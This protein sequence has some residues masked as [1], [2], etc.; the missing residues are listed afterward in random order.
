MKFH[1]LYNF[2]GTGTEQI[3][4][5]ANTNLPSAEDFL[6]QNANVFFNGQF[7]NLSRQLLHVSLHAFLS[8][9]QTV[10]HKHDIRPYESLDIRNVPLH[11]I[12]VYVPANRK[13]GFHGMGVFILVEDED[14]RAVALTKSS[15][16]ESLR[17]SP[18]FD[19]DTYKK[20]TITTGTTTTLW[21][22]ASDKDIG[23]Y[24]V[25]MSVAGAQ[26]IELEWTDSTGSSGVEVIG[27]YRFGSEGTYTMDFDTA[28]LRNPN[29]Q[30]GLLRAITTT[31]ASTQ[32]DCIGH[33]IV[34]SQ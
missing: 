24:K 7:T 5:V 15:L 8:D 28:M 26:T 3:T 17:S 11:K 29:G 1:G 6:S 31:T 16:S 9:G 12:Q 27:L 33:E 20:S 34:A 2:A 23:L 19:T 14:E 25:N 10:M 32:I 13:V 30:N 18:N 4:G 22:P 21:T